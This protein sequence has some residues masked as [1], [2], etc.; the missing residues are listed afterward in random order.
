MWSKYILY[1]QLL[2]PWKTV[3]APELNINCSN[4]SIYICNNHI[5]NGTL[6]SRNLNLFNSQLVLSN[7]PCH[8]EIMMH[9][10]NWKSNLS[11]VYFLV[12]KFR[13]NM[14]LSSF[15]HFAFFKQFILLFL[16]SRNSLKHPNTQGDNAF[17]NFCNFPNFNKTGLCLKYFQSQLNFQHKEMKE[18]IKLSKSEF[19]L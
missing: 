15:F 17:C 12:D 18:L 1:S 7:T 5:H 3:W 2:L 16:W 11:E 10:A 4:I 8:N 9:F 13:I 19:W 14:Y 6:L